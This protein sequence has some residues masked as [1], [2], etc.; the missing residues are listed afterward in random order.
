MT[1]SEELQLFITDLLFDKIE[2]SES[3][4]LH[5]GYLVVLKSFYYFSK[6]VPNK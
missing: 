3:C 1:K 2:Y 5:E 6:P 4:N